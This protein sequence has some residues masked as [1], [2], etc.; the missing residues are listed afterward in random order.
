MTP[1]RDCDHTI[2][3]VHGA[4]P[5]NLRHYGYSHD[6][7]DAVEAIISDMLQDKT[8]VPRKSDFAS[9][10]LLVKK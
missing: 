7:K 1:Q 10:A 3:L 8:V 5:F 2:N 9:P 6:Q 4:Q